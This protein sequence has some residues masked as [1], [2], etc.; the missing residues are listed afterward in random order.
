MKGAIAI[1]A[2][3]PGLTPTK[4]RLAKDLGRQKT[5]EFYRLSLEAI[6]ETL[7][8]AQRQ[9]NVEIY[10]ALAEENGKSDWS[11]FPH[12]WTG[13]GDFGQRLDQVYSK[14]IK[15]YDFVSLIGT[16]SPQIKAEDIS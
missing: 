12:F 1:L 6:E 11:N 14:L 3:T 10:W 4:T 2:K 13:E 7:I 9:E 15:D 5:D 16:D 8:E